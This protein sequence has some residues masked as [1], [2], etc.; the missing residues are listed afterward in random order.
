MARLFISAAH[1]SSG[2]TTLSIGLAA[3]LKAR[4]QSPQVFKKGPDYIDPLWLAQASGR[5]VYNLD[6]NTQTPE[7]IGAL[8]ASRQS[9]DGFNLIEGN[10]GLHD[11]VDV[12]GSDSSSALAKLLDAPVVL[13]ID[14]HGMTRG[15]APLLMGYQV[16]DP[17]VKITG[18]V[19]N[20][21]ATARQES[22]LRAAIEAYTDIKVL[23][24]LPRSPAVIVKERHL[25][26]TTPGDADGAPVRIEAIRR[27]IES[28][29]DISALEAIGR[30]ASR[31]ANVV[32]LPAA[33]PHTG[34]TIAVARD[35]AFCFYYQDDLEALEAAG[36]RLVEFS[37]LRDARLPDA[38]AL[39]LGGGFPETHIAALSANAPM[40]D[41]IRDAANAG[42]PIH[43]ECGGLMYLTRT[44]THGAL[45]GPMAG[46]I[47]ADAVIRDRPQG[48][49]LVVLEPKTGGA[50]VQ[51]HEFHHGRLENLAAETEFA[52]QVK[53]G[54]GIDGRHDGIKIN[55]V[56]ASFSHLR[57]T[58]RHHWTQEFLALAAKVKQGRKPAKRNTLKAGR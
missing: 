34:L 58:S 4:G 13:V 46:V 27:M 30:T 54:E 9:P 38:D 17:A 5:P 23:G 44:L 6:F 49:G 32:L 48:R 20:Q 29:V 40:R 43:A 57:D 28:H 42:L 39:L 11:G 22:K 53:R 21:V 14:A 45:S 15:I 3:S 35:E 51:A 55:N 7:E 16:F 47:A 1:K 8:Y 10:K 26:L 33:R 36:A 41:A 12:L 2:K 56:T 25:G 18:V 24:A 50:P 37:P 31:L 19:L 52:W